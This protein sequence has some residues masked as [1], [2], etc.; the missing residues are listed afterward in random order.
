[1]AAVSARVREYKKRVQALEAEMA[2]RR[3]TDPNWE[4]TYR[5]R[6]RKIRSETFGAD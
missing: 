1:M 4:A 3:D 5:Q 2:G 6:L